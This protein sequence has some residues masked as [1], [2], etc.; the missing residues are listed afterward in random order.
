MNQRVQI[1][2]IQAPFA[3]LVS[4]ALGACASTVVQPQFESAKLQL[5]RPDRIL[6]YDF[7]VST[8]EVTENQGFFQQSVNEFRDVTP[9]QHEQ[10]I[11]DEV[12]KVAAEEIIEGIHN[13]G[14]PAERAKRDSPV[15]AGSLAI[16]GQ[17]LNVDEGNKLRRTVIGFGAGQSRVDIQVQMYGYGL[18][19]AGSS[20]TGP[21]KLADFQT[22]A[23]SGSMPGALVTAGAGAAASGGMTAGVAA[24]NVGISGVKSYRSAMG[25]MTSRSAEQAVAY[26]SEFFG[27]QGWIATDKVTYGKRK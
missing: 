17:F 11:A 5:Q 3:V 13:L 15:P 18:G 24:A 23:D 27:R 14:L 6:V 16:T 9:Y 26:M 7:A 21:T 2:S 10:E 25:Q 8:K 1:H 20:Q 4:V 22:A 19:P 12:K